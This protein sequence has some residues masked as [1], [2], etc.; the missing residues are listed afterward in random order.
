MKKQQN[1]NFIIPIWGNTFIEN[2]LN[3]SLISLITKKNL[4]V[5]K[6]KNSKLIFCTKKKKYIT[7]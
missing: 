3:F 6:K 4:Q 2:A 7:Y 5:I 1:I